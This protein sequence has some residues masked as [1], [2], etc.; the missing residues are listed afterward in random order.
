M[1]RFMFY[2]NFQ[3]SSVVFESVESPHDKCS[4]RYVTT[5]LDTLYYHNRFTLG[6]ISRIIIL[7]DHTLR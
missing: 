4:I 5:S 1:L 6:A 7:K 2:V 3:L